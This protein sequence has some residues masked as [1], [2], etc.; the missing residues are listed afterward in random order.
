MGGHTMRRISWWGDFAVRLRH[1]VPALGGCQ[2]E[3]EGCKGAAG[4]VRVNSSGIHHRALVMMAG[5]TSPNGL[6]GLSQRW[7]SPEYRGIYDPAAWVDS[8]RL[9]AWAGWVSTGQHHSLT[10]LPSPTVAA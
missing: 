10:P 2:R 8:P 1:C 9:C 4:E 5:R 3:N 7:P 6:S